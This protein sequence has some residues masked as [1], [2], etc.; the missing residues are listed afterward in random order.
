MP[1]VIRQ[2]DEARWLD[3]NVT[4]TELLV[5]FDSEAMLIVPW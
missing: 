3:P 4:G 1:V 5:P 2:Q